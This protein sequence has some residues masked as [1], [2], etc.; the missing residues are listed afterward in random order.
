MP[1]RLTKTDL[2]KFLH[3]QGYDPACGVGKWVLESWLA[4]ESE[5]SREIK[6]WRKLHGRAT[7]G[8]AGY[9]FKWV[10]KHGKKKRVEVPEERRTMNWIVRQKLDGYS[11]R[12]LYNHLLE[13]SVMTHRGTPWS[14]S[15]IRRG[16]LAELRLQVEEKAAATDSAAGQGGE[17]PKAGQLDQADGRGVAGTD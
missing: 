4:M 12:E 14:I 16:Y 2:V 5:R 13:N 17:R 3:Q 6:G 8:Y 7:N 11:W 1:G 9:G 10:G 15:R